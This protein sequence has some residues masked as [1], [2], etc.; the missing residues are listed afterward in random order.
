MSA[1]EILKSVDQIINDGNSSNVSLWLKKELPLYAKQ[2]SIEFGKWA[3]LND[4]TYLKS[5][6][7][8]VN[9]EEEENDTTYTNEQVYNLFLEHQLKQTTP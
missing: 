8:W 1:E 6:D 2:Q 7:Y 9:E 3:T 5:K 4:W